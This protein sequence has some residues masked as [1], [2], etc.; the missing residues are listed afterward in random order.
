MDCDIGIAVSIAVGI[1]IERRRNPF[2]DLPIAVVVN[3]VA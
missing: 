3:P 2:I 1:A